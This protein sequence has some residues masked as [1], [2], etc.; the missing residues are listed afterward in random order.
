MEAGQGGEFT[1]RTLTSNLL[2]KSLKFMTSCIFFFN[3]FIRKKRKEFAKGIG[4]SGSGSLESRRAQGHGLQTCLHIGISW[5]VIFNNQRALAAPRPVKSAPR[6]WDPRVTIPVKLPG[7]P[8]CTVKG[9]E[10]CPEGGL[11]DAQGKAGSLQCGWL[12]WGE[13]VTWPSVSLTASGSFPHLIMGS[14]SSLGVKSSLRISSQSPFL[15]TRWAVPLSCL[16]QFFPL[17]NKFSVCPVRWKQK[18]ASLK[19]QC[20]HSH[21]DT[22][23]HSGRARQLWVREGSRSRPLSLA[24]HTTPW[25]VFWRKGIRSTH[26]T[27]ESCSTCVTHGQ[28]RHVEPRNS[29]VFLRSILQALD[30]WLEMAL[31]INV[32]SVLC[33]VAY[34][35]FYQGLS[36]GKIVREGDL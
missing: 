30:F 19:G 6:A 35:I 1:T 29:L 14:G 32:H 21:L 31:M 3:S 9:W 4:S 11:L 13:A 15:E 18:G 8:K 25:I 5:R 16:I 7:G 28:V 24:N 33:P 36:K 34:F 17:M 22:V 20:H 2:E 12:T 10:G 23:T 26:V 27:H